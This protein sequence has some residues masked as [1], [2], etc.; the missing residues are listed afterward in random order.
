MQEK[1]FSVRYIQDYVCRQTVS[2]LGGPFFL[3]E[4]FMVIRDLRKTNGTPEINKVAL[5]EPVHRAVSLVRCHRRAEYQ[6]RLHRRAFDRQSTLHFYHI[7][8]FYRI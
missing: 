1:M 3:I 4:C 2:F 8:I 6:Y 5:K 7:G